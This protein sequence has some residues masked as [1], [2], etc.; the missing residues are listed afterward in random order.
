LQKRHRIRVYFLR[1]I[2]GPQNLLNTD[3]VDKVLAFQVG[4]MCP[5]FVVC[6]VIPNPLRHCKD[7]AAIIHVQ[8]EA[9][10]DKL[11]VA[12][13]REGLSGSLPRSG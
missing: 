11:T 7:E 5:F 8:P 12:I 10:T 13:A 1:F 4:Q 6:K 9:A 3:L 2:G